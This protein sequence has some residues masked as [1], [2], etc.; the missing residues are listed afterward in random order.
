MKAILL[1]EW[2]LHARH[3][4]IAAVA[5]VTGLWSTGILLA[6]VAW[7]AELSAWALFF[8]LAGIGLFFVPALTTL[9][10]G[11]GVRELCR[12]SPVGQQQFLAVRVGSISLL[13]TLAGSFVLVAAG[14]DAFGGRILGVLGLAIVTSFLSVIAL[15]STTAIPEYFGRV[16]FIAIP[17]LLPPMLEASGLVTSPLLSLSPV[18]S[19]MRLIRA[20]GGTLD[21]IW[22]LAWAAAL[23]FPALRAWGAT[24]SHMR[25]APPAPVSR[26][27]AHVQPGWNAWR[28]AAAVDRRTLTGDRLLVMVATGVPVL[29][30]AVRWLDGA[31]AT[32]LLGRWGFDITPYLSLA[33]AFV[34]VVHTPLMIGAVSGLVFLEDRDAGVLPA[35]KVTHWSLPGLVTWRMAITAGITVAAVLVGV[36]VAGA[37]PSGGWLGVLASAVSAGVLSTTVAM[38]LASLARDRVQGMAVMKVMGL[39]F[40]GSL[41]SWFMS[42]AAGLA[43]LVV[44]SGW[45][46]RAFWASSSVA[47]WLWAAGGIVWSGMLTILLARRFDRSA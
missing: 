17:L 8:D 23:A 25:W 28:S 6:P 21:A 27:V 1:T 2:R 46:V 29:A 16:P 20:S 12:I 32:W 33:W 39:P 44:P 10:R 38:L 42:G 19:A 26:P 24:G 9:E 22:L 3:G 4:V 45:T 14:V 31:G 15:G 40:Y 13:A 11:N 41:A 30:V 18:T 43:W 47:A 5:V 35:V 7:R 37:V 34:L 36:P